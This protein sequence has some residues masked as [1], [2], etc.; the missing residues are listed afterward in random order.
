M[1]LFGIPVV[2]DFTPPPTEEELEAAGENF[3]QLK[4]D[5]YG[6]TPENDEFETAMNQAGYMPSWN[7]KEQRFTFVP[8]HFHNGE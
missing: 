8:L 7:T 2:L 1:K 6:G 5:G 4:A 3:T